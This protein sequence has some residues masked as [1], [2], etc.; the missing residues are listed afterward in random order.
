MVNETIKLMLEHAS[1]R[2]FTAEK[3]PAATL[4]TIIEAGRAASTWKNFQSYSIINVQTDETKSKIFDLQPQKSIKQASHFLVF[5]G[6]LNRA[7]KA[8]KLHTDQFFP[9]GTENLLISS[10]DAS[11][12]AQNTL[13]A[14]ESLGYGGVIVGLI[15][16]QAAEISNLL[17]LPDYT[18]PL[19]GLA[20]GVPARQNDVKPR[21]PY[22]TIV[23]DERYQEQTIKVIEDYD[24][25]QAEFAGARRLSSDW[26]ERIATQFGVPSQTATLENLQDK[27]LM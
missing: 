2:N 7:E 26:S 16:D 1:V 17:H 8:T 22:E 23:F 10:V 12:A 5:V 18:Y 4:K 11:L 15:R 6:D 20:L 25:L 24:R 9:E 14:A 3:I 19:F 13:L 21:L 27:K